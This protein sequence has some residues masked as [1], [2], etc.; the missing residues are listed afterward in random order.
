MHCGKDRSQKRA[1][2]FAAIL[3]FFAGGRN[4]IRL[5]ASAIP[6]PIA[7]QLFVGAWSF[8]ENRCPLFRIML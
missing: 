7:L 3:G 4:P 2:A 8:S 1:V 5:K 6:N